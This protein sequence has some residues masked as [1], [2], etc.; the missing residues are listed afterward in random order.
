MPIAVTVTRLTAAVEGCSWLVLRGGCGG[1]LEGGVA[2]V[3][4]VLGLLSVE[5]LLDG[6]DLQPRV[7]GSV[8]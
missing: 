7:A 1:F 5:E 8:G 4:W 2:A 6:E 3:K